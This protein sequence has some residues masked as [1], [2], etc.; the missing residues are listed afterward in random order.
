MR[1]DKLH[2]ILTSDLIPLHRLLYLVDEVRERLG[3]ISIAAREYRL[4][5]GA[6]LFLRW[7][8]TDAKVFDE[9]FFERIYQPFAEMIPSDSVPSVLV[10]L[11]ANIGLS[12]LFLERLLGFEHIIAVEPD[13]ANL[14]LLRQNLDANVSAEVTSLQAFAGGQRGYANLLDSGNGSWGLRMGEE[15]DYGIPVLPLKEIIPSVPGG[16]LLKCDIEGAERHLFPRIAEWDELVSFIILELHTEFFSF[17]QLQK[18]LEQSH[19][20][21]HVQGSV[22]EGAVLTVLALER[23]ALKAEPVQSGSDSRSHSRGAAA[24]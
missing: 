11:G 9:V 13:R 12:G 1:L 15:T 23:G 22:P 24:M 21:W 17:A 2:R 4:I 18:A 3:L 8:S 10:D 16:V 6:H 5:G 7:N 20:D 19:Y 14:R